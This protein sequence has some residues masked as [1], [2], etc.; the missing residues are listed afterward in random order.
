MP[1]PETGGKGVSVITALLLLS[2]IILPF[3]LTILVEQNL[4]DYEQSLRT[5]LKFE[6]YLREQATPDQVQL[7]IEQVKK[8]EGFSHFN[9]RDRSEVFKDMQLALGATL[10][11]DDAPNPFPSVVEVS[12]VPQYS[13]LAHFEK[14]NL[15]T[16]K[17]PFIEDVNY[18]AEWLEAHEKTFASANKILTAMRMITTGCALILM[19]WF[20]KRIILGRS[21]YYTILRRLGA[22]WRVMA[23][24]F[25]IR[26]TALGVAGAGLSLLA[27]YGCFALATGWSIEISFV[28][29]T[30]MLAVL[31]FGGL[32]ALL[33]AT[34]AVGPEL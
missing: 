33:S 34:L 16:K 23:F 32:V 14:V 26:K 6:I 11:P 8:L 25:I 13:T 28:T 7:V 9:Y 19:F 10:L 20:M 3:G 1:Q 4:H 24:P 29:S 30:N 17:F 27:L 22:G 15:S 12:F 2:L 21:E 18:G 5:R 31:G